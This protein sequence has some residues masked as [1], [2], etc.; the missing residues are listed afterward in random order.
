ME[1]K[2]SKKKWIIIAVIVVII[3]IVAVSGNDNSPTPVANENN[4]SQTTEKK[5]ETTEAIEYS[6]VTIADLYDDL[7]AN[8]YNA[9]EK[10]NGKYIEVSGKVGTIDASGEYFC[11]EY[12]GGGYDYIFNNVQVFLS[13]SQKDVL[14]K[15]SKD[16]PITVRCKVTD[17]GEV[18]GYL[19]NF[20][21]I[22]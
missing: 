20:I 11:V 21:E 4:A 12:D 10:W 19:A 3:L 5:T 9:K 13:N 7:Q 2:K 17:V 16:S 14:G 1:K 6:K 8:A 18:I 22:A 15:I